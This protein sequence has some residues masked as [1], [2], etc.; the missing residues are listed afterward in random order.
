MITPTA[1][2]EREAVGV[3]KIDLRIVL[4]TLTTAVYAL[5]F[6]ALYGDLGAGTLTLSTIP[7]ALT[8]WL[9][10][11][12]A[13]MIFGVL[14][15]PLN[16][17]L[18]WSAQSIDLATVIW[19][20][21]VAACAALL[22]GA[23]AGTLHDVNE[24]LHTDLSERQSTEAEL[25]ESEERLRHLVESAPGIL[26]TV[27]R[28][29]TVLYSNQP[30][31]TVGAQEAPGTNV[32]DYVPE[33]HH[34]LFKSTLAKVFDGGEPAGYEISEADAEAGETVLHVI[35]LGPVRRNGRVVAATLLGVEVVD[36]YD[37][38]A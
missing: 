35:R 17:A 27:D 10:G 1:G 36:Q 38:D 22:V 26:I 19:G 12:R 16:A 25:R 7:V 2:R 11:L 31:G 34:W 15:F 8:G 21:G 24:Q 32:Y 14:A 9:F 4:I 13:G 3:E 30:L 6:S 29:G 37:P 18:L 28:D 5:S 33:D 20:G 23:V